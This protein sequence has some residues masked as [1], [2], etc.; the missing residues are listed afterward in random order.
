MS[1]LYEAHDLRQ[2]YN[3]VTVLEISSFK[4]EKGASLVLTGP[5]GSGKSTFLRL[6]SFLEQPSSG[7]LK[8]YGSTEP[9][10][11]CPLLLQEAWLL[12][13]TVFQNVVLGL[14]LRGMR[15]NLMGKFCRAMGAAGF[16]QPELF[17]RRRPGSLSGGEKQRVALASRLILEPQVLL[18]DEP[19]AYV[20][21]KSAACI[22]SALHSEQE[23]GASIICA[24]HD[25]GLAR[26][27]NAARMELTRP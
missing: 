8:Y 3:G 5:N 2:I 22:S 20:D 14:Q 16:E 17:I 7:S 18:L 19:T 23:R 12:H 27:L 26:S 10:L 15:D 11:E 6:L 24:T 9:R 13:E 25:M 4:L 1:L 21:Q